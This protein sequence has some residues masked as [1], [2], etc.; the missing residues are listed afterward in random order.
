MLAQKVAEA[1]AGDVDRREHVP[2]RL[3]AGVDAD[4]IVAGRLDEQAP[5][6]GRI[7]RRRD[8]FDLRVAA[9]RGQVVVPAV[10][11]GEIVP[12]IPPSESVADAGGS[13]TTV[14]GTSS[15][16]SS[17]RRSIIQ[18]PAAGVSLT[19]TVS[20]GTSPRSRS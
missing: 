7:E 13:S 5:G 2:S 15:E 20:P 4:V 11:R 3:A 12:D 10:A 1:L 18:K 9:R 19:R 17:P 8:E 16:K 14:M 6:E